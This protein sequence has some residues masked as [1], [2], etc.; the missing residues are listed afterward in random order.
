MDKKTIIIIVA[1]GL[2]IVGLA[3]AGYF[4]WNWLNK[5]NMKFL[6]N[7]DDATSKIT[8][9]ATKGVLP[10]LGVNPLENK[11]DIN[12]ADAG[13]PIKNIKINPFE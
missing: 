5:S 7:I 6:E 12:P 3:I 10:S 9:S 13:N 4:Y 11:P 1:A 8:D 2:L